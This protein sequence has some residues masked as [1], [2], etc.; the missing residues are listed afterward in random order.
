VFVDL[1]TLTDIVDLSEYDA[2]FMKNYVTYNDRIM[3]IPTGANGS[4]FAYNTYMFNKIGI[5]PPKAL[6][7]DQLLVLG[8]K[9]HTYDKDSYLLLAAWETLESMLKA[10]VTQNT[11]K[12]YMGENF[13]MGFT[14]AD[15]QEAY[16]YLLKMSDNYVLEPFEEMAVY[17]ASDTI[18]TN[19]KF[20]QEKLVAQF[21][22]PSAINQYINLLPPDHK[23]EFERYAV[24]PGAKMTGVV[25]RPS[26]II[27]IYGKSKFIKEAG[28]FINDMVK[29]ED[30]IIALSDQRGVPAAKT[31]RDILITKDLINPAIIKGVE[32]AL[33]AA[34]LPENGIITDPE[35]RDISMEMI[36]KVAFKMATPAQAAAE[37]IKLYQSRL[38]EMK[39]V[40][41]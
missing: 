3:G 15:L 27:S 40:A 30:Y 25:C 39:A 8:R 17:A 31:A 7:W 6:D 14:R 26:Q 34:G 32:V 37:A 9:V 18:A 19:P 16:E 2:N 33:A 28:K 4:A 29:V 24:K 5:E 23:I 35:I 10:Y 38:D 20:S 1:N 12:L 21:S 13:T 41:K 11:G 36:Q 22:M